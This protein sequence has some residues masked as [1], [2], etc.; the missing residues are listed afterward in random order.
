MGCSWKRVREFLA[1]IDDS[2]NPRQLC[3]FCRYT[4]PQSIEPSRTEGYLQHLVFGF[5]YVFFLHPELGWN[6]D[7]HHDPRFKITV[8]SGVKTL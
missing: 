5:R 1:L 4:D 8:F 6:D 2:F 3:E 7:W